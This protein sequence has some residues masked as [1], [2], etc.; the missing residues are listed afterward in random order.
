MAFYTKD[1][2]PGRNTFTPKE[3]QFPVDEELFC[4]GLI[5]YYSQPVGVIVAETQVLAEQAAE[6]VEITYES[7]TVK[8]LF[9]V[10]QILEAGDISKIS[11]EKVLKPIKTGIVLS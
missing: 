5:Q 4:S 6:M 9:T 10:R 11:Q 7:S 3:S 1:D 8:P 2:I